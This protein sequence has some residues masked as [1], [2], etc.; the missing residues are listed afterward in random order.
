[1]NEAGKNLPLDR[2]ADLDLVIETQAEARIRSSKESVYVIFNTIGTR[3]SARAALRA[4]AERS[5]ESMLTSLT[6]LVDAIPTE[7]DGSERII[8]F[9]E[10]LAS[11]TATGVEMY[12]GSASDGRNKGPQR[13]VFEDELGLKVGDDLDK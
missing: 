3:L 6:T 8:A 12:R 5:I 10:G 4:R 13:Q 2:D 1:M 7:G 9:L 11:M